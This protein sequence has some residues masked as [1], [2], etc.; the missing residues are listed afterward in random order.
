MPILK[1]NFFGFNTFMLFGLL[2]CLLTDGCKEEPPYI[3]ICKDGP[4][5]YIEFTKEPEAIPFLNTKSDDS[6]EQLV[7]QSQS[8]LERLI[9]T[10]TRPTKIDFRTQTLLAGRKYAITQA[11]VITQEII[12][13]CKN[14]KIDYKIS[15]KYTY[16]SDGVAQYFAIIPKI[17]E[18]TKVSFIVNYVN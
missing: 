14:T 16:L 4:I 1:R 17:S 18:K 7:I 10:K 12:S 2:I 9:N 6:N 13:D 8:E 15:L 5:E 3:I 11:V